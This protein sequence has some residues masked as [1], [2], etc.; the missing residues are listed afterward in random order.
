MTLRLAQN[1]FY[2]VLMLAVSFHIGFGV[3]GEVRRNRTIHDFGESHP[4]TL[5]NFS[6]SR[7]AIGI[8]SQC[9]LFPLFLRH[10][11]NIH[12]KAATPVKYLPHTFYNVS[13][14]CQFRQ[15]GASVMSKST[16]AAHAAK[17]REYK[18][19]ER[20]D[21]VGFLYRHVMRVAN[22]GPV[23]TAF[24][25]AGRLGFTPPAVRL[26][27]QAFYELPV[28]SREEI[29]AGW[30]WPKELR[31]EI[32]TVTIPVMRIRGGRE[33]ENF[34]HVD[35][36]VGDVSEYDGVSVTIPAG[37]SY[38][39]AVESLRR[40]LSIVQKRWDDLPGQADGPAIV[41]FDFGNKKGEMPPTHSTGQIA[42]PNGEK[43]R[44]T[45]PAGV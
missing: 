32:N 37:T 30:V 12:T 44:K 17:V 6:N 9:R 35:Y 14:I 42:T 28:S 23:R 20:A 34:A 13:Y 15:A 1:L 5:S 11:G 27:Y 22:P 38:A 25:N 29:L 45:T 24:E 3:V 16:S 33:C 19:K 21:M 43:A 39:H 36:S 8:E 2:G 7:Q 31:R 40:A 4:G 26:A 10:G 18:E 41:A